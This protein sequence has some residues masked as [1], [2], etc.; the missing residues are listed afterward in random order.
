MLFFTALQSSPI[1]VAMEVFMLHYISYSNL[2][3]ATPHLWAV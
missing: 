3:S 1:T 2:V